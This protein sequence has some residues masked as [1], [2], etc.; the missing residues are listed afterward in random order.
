MLRRRSHFN[1]RAP[2][3]ARHYL[4]W[5]ANLDATFQPTRPL[6]GATIERF[7]SQRAIL[8]STHAP[9]AGRDPGE[10]DG[11]PD[12]KIST[13]APL[14]GRDVNSSSLATRTNGFQPTRPLRGATSITTRRKNQEEISTHAPLAGRDEKYIELLGHI[15]I[16][17]HA[18]LAGRDEE[19][20]QMARTR[21]KFQPTRPLRGATT[22]CSACPD[23]PPN[24]NP[25]APCGARH[26]LRTYKYRDRQI[27]T[28]APLAGRDKPRL[29]VD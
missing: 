5:K 26:P 18:P 19:A 28:H 2:C 29:V 3:G 22:C 4:A 9:L 16:S 1:P 21:K 27:S 25:R 8:I 14:A 24:F 7:H 6:R 12:Q 23:A 10:H 11:S 13:H 20:A 17:T 15:H